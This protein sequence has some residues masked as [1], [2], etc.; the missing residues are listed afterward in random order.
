MLD[1]LRVPKEDIQKISEVVRQHG[2][3]DY[4]FLFGSYLNHPLEDSD[5]DIL[6]GASLEP[7]ERL[8]L[9]MQL[10]LILKRKV[11]IVIAAEASCELLLN[12]LSQG[13][14]LIINDR[15]RLKKDYFKN[16]RLFDERTSLRMLR[17]AKIKSKYRYA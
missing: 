16:F 15:E 6:L 7:S 17:T 13:L 2:R 1:K 12:A 5:V 3:I 14:P 10:E 8:N 9:A 11:D 4:A